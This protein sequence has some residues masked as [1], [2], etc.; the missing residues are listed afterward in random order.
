MGKYNPND[1]DLEPKGENEYKSVLEIGLL[2]N[3]YPLYEGITR[4]KVVEEY[5]KLYCP[6]NFKLI[7]EKGGFGEF[8][9][10]N[11]ALFKR[12]Y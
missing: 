6:K 12:N 11:L 8:Y 2:K 4:A 5:H 3:T 9:L 7:N 10:F 1:I